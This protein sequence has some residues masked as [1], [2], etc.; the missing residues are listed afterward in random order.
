MVT[1]TKKEDTENKTNM[2]DLD[3]TAC[4]NVVVTRQIRRL[5]SKFP[6]MNEIAIDCWTHGNHY[7]KFKLTNGNNKFKWYTD[8]KESVCATDGTLYKDELNKLLVSTYRTMC[9]NKEGVDISDTPEELL[10]YAESKL[11]ELLKESVA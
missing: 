5:I 10:A 1:A 2:R 8:T 7:V 6:S 11:Q 9:E 4:T 3:D